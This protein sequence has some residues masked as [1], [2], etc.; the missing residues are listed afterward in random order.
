MGLQN[1][2]SKKD[3]NFQF[4]QN[5]SLQIRQESIKYIEN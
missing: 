1:Y 4:I 5:W 3:K 2:A